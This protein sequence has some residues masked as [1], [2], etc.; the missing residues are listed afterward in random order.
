[1]KL[2]VELARR[3]VFRTAGVY[4]VGAWLIVQVA[5][6]LLLV[7]NAPVWIMKAIVIFLAV[8]FIPAMVVS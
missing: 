4:L 5:A 7:F 6:T 2:I 8:G 3:N 1:M